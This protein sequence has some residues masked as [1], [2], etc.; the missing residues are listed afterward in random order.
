MARAIGK[1]FESAAEPARMRTSKISSVAYATDERAS[2]EKIARAATFERR[3]WGASAVLRG[4]PMSFRFNVESGTSL[5]CVK[6]QGRKQVEQATFSPRGQRY[7]RASARGS[8]VDGPTLE[9]A[10]SQC[11]RGG[12]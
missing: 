9:E 1:D 10:A 8:Q 12:G 2:D 4:V 5:L 6:V 11:R 7:A 3:S